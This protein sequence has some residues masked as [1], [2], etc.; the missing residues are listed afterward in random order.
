MRILLFALL[1]QDEAVFHATAALEHILVIGVGIALADD[2]RAAQLERR[3]QVCCAG[4]LDV[5]RRVAGSLVR[6]AHEVY[7]VQLADVGIGDAFELGCG[8]DATVRCLRPRSECQA[9]H[10]G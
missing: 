8:A 3:G 9:L 10:L 4:P 2:V 6:A 7:L 5:L 1:G